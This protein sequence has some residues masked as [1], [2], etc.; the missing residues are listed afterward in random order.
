MDNEIQYLDQILQTV[1][2]PGGLTAIANGPGPQ[3]PE[4]A[5]SRN[6]KLVHVH[7]LF[8]M[9]MLFLL[10][11]QDQVD[12]SQLQ[13]IRLTPPGVPHS[14][15][16]SDELRRHMTIRLGS[17][18]MYYMRGRHNIISLTLT[19]DTRVPGVDYTELSEALSQ[20]GADNDFEHTRILTAL[21]ISTLRRLLT[22][23]K[24]TA[25]APAEVVASYIRGNYYRNDLSIREIA[26]IT[27]FSPHYI[28][29]VFRSVWNCTPIEYLNEVRL[30]AARLLLSQHRW[31]VQEVASMCGWNY[32]HYFCRR[33]KE[34]FGNLPGEE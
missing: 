9:R 30:N 11:S 17:N 26:E 12:Y 6:S 4:G 34:Y 28:Q 13:E 5:C 29:K 18:E 20:A 23:E 24:I 14:S 33:Y 8:E 15:M 21:L 2:S 25:P 10:N 22:D 32:V 31:Q 27:G 7:D 19:P 16:S 1:L 3:L